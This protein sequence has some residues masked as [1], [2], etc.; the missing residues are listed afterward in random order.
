MRAGRLDR[1]VTLQ[2]AITTQDAY[3]EEIKTW[4]DIADVWAERVELRGVERF[5]AQQ[6][7][8]HVDAKYRI[9]WMAGLT[10]INRLIDADG[11]VYDIQAVLEI[12]R[13]EGLEL[14]VSA[15]V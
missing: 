8:A 7:Q 14:Q 1:L 6:T 12:G 10:P 11:R 15:S 2:R 13:R 5:E 9:R 4:S 3:G